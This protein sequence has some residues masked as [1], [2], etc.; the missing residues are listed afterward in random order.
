MEVKV[1]IEPYLDFGTNSFFWMLY[2]YYYYHSAYSQSI[3]SCR[4][5]RYNNDLQE[6]KKM[7]RK[8]SGSLLAVL[9]IRI[10]CIRKI[11]ASWIRIRL[12][13]KMRIQGSGSKR[14]NINQKLKKNS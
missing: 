13:K 1:I 10:R 12:G 9:I 5:L 8:Q 4:L 3:M 11:L 14:Q 7:K 6:I 2:N